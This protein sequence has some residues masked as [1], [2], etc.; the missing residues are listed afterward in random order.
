MPRDTTPPAKRIISDPPHDGTIEKTHPA[1]GMLAISRVSGSHGSKLFGSDIEPSST[2]QIEVT[3]GMEH[4]HLH[5]KW[6]HGGRKLL[7]SLEMSAIQFAEAITTLNH[8][9]GVPCTIRFA[10]GKEVPGFHD[11]DNL[12]QQIKEDLRD[13]TKEISAGLKTLETELVSALAE[14]GMSKVRQKRIMDVITRVRMNLDSNMPFVLEQYQEALDKTRAAAKADV[15]AFLLHVLN[16][17]GVQSLQQLTD[18][19]GE[20]KRIE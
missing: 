14:S 10:D 20:K 6:F 11:D 8:G 3:Q 15:D 1:F 17:L 4:W 9:S 2:I 19:I 5:Q 13:D 7:V 16:K 12:H 18:A